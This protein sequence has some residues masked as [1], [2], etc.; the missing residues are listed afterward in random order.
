MPYLARQLADDPTSP[1]PSRPNKSSSRIHRTAQPSCKPQNAQNHHLQWRSAPY[2]YAGNQTNSSCAKD[3]HPN[4]HRGE[5][6][7]AGQED[8]FAGT[9]GIDIIVLF[10]VPFFF[11]K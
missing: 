7:V 2:D 3:L 1:P 8:I 5:G 9:L 11:Y 6:R 10:V 4:S